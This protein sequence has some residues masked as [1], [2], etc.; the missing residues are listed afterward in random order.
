MNTTTL[1]SLRQA[2]KD[3]ADEKTRD[4]SKRFFKEPV[5]LYGVKAATVRKIAK[6]HFIDLKNRTKNEVFDICEPLWKSGYLEEITVACEWIYR[7]SKDFSPEDFERFEIWIDKYVS[8]WA[9]CDVFCNHSVG[10]FL[11]M[12]PKYVTELKKWAKSANPWKRRAAAVSLIIPARKGLFH[13]DIFQIAKI[14]LHDKEDLVQKGYG[15]MLKAAADYDCDAVFEFVMKHKAT[16][17]RT[18]LRYAIEK[19]PQQTRKIAM[20]VDHVR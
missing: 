16:M 12:H 11:E 5:K 10:T 3:A 15:W 17:P 9:A 20:A 18:A 2:L 8:N 14:L 6:E 19:M 13:K 1:K 4:S 7:F